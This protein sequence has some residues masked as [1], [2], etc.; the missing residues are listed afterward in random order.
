VLL[1]FGCKK[2]DDTEC[3]CRGRFQNAQG[4]IITANP[5]NCETGEPTTS[6][7]ITFLGCF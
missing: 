7:T 6:P 1:A 4:E 2:D 5:V 3:T